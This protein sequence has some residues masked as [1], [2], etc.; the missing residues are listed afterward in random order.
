MKQVWRPKNK[1]DPT[2]NKTLAQSTVYSR[3]RLQG[4]GR[5]NWKHDPMSCNLKLS[6]A[7]HYNTAVTNMQAVEQRQYISFF[8][9]QGF[10][11]TMIKGQIIYQWVIWWSID[12]IGQGLVRWVPVKAPCLPHP[13]PLAKRLYPNKL[14]TDHPE[15]MSFLHLCVID[16]AFDLRLGMWTF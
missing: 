9:L 4:S 3:N 8:L 16:I 6:T 1:S 15:A 7:A 10:R 14:A 11:M 13:L 5:G 12:E 2:L